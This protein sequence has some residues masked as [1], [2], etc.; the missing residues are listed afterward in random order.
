MTRHKAFVTAAFR[1]REDPIVWTID[2]IDVRLRASV[3]LAAIGHLIDTLQEEPEDGSTGMSA[4]IAKRTKLLVAIR[5]F[6]LPE[7]HDAFDRVADDLDFTVL[8]EMSTE[9]IREYS[10]AGNPTRPGSSSDGSE[11]TGESSTD[12]AQP[13]ESTPSLSLSTG[14]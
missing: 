3:D 2:E 10:G 12:G 7:S 13:E 4:A 8:S 5:Q 14:A 6:V 1:R 11:A 9:L